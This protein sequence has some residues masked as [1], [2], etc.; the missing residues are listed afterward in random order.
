MK[1]KITTKETTSLVNLIYGNNQGIP[2]VGE[3]ATE[4]LWSDR[5]AYDVIE[6]SEDKKTAWIKRCSSD[7]IYKVVYRN[8]AWRKEFETADFLPEWTAKFPVNTRYCEM[9]TEDERKAVY[10]DHIWPCNVVEGITYRKIIYS[11]INIIFGV[12]EEYQ[13]PT[14]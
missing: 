13:D 4:L 11:K 3:G 10:Q 2:V 1:S 14:F 7:I 5:L 6:V 12:K 9:L 8:R